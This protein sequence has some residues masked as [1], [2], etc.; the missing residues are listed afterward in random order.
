MD[1]PWRNQTIKKHIDAILNM[2]WSKNNTGHVPILGGS[3]SAD[4]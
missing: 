2:D 3:K 4:L 1:D